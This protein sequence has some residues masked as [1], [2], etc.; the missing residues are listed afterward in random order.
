MIK[1]TS[2]SVIEVKSPN[3]RYFE[4]AILF[5]KDIQPPEPVKL[6]HIADAYLRES[7]R[8]YKSHLFLRLVTGA[9]RFVLAA[10]SG[11]AITVLLLQ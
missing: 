8:S 3:S 6:S 7:D 9:L 5:L 10:C 4:R 11:A 1:G 2:K